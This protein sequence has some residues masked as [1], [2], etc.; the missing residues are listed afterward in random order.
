VAFINLKALDE[1]E[2]IAGY[3]AVIVHS[4]S[5]D[6]GILG[7]SRGGSDARTFTCS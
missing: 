2:P 7:G 4:E 3:K 6:T 1:K 5:N